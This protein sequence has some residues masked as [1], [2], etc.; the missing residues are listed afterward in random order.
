MTIER[1]V[2]QWEMPEANK[3]QPVEVSF[4]ADWDAA[5]L[6]RKTYTRATGVSAYETA[7]LGSLVGVWNPRES[8][9]VATWSPA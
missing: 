3:G 7:T 8:E 5:K 6:W 9:P 2:S 4:G 1:G